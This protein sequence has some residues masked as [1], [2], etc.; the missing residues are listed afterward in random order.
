MSKTTVD[1][2]Q[3]MIEE[4]REKLARLKQEAREE[5]IRL[6]TLLAVQRRT[7]VPTK[8]KIEKPS[9]KISPVVIEP[10]PLNRIRRAH[11]FLI[12]LGRAA[13][14]TEILEG[15]GEPTNTQSKKDLGALMLRNHKKGRL[16]RR[17]EAWVYEA[18]P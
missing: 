4:S 17:V 1:P 2:T 3:A 13:H 6:Q 12:K 16:F 11:E 18:I 9:A 14:V 8:I 15:I 5:E 7:L 10:K